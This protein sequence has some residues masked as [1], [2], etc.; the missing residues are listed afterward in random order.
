M[1]TLLIK[2]KLT[3]AINDIEDPDFLSALHTIVRN[4]MEEEHISA[5]SAAQKKE[6][7]KRKQSHKKGLS[8]SYSLTEL[9]KSLPKGQI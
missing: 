3:K 1:T 8:K 5:L 7:D 9:K 6:L 4:K 2:K